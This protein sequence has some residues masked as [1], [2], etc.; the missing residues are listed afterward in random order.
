[1]TVESQNVRK[2]QGT[3]IA[4]QRL[5]ERFVATITLVKIKVLPRN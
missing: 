3:S 1:M 4:G 2:S 5:A